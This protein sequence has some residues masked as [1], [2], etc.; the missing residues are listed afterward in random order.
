MRRGNAGVR[1]KGNDVS[2]LSMGWALGREDKQRD[3][4][5]E[6]RRRSEIDRG[7]PEGLGLD[8]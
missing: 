1:R 5:K 3:Q 2:S 6:K 4:V 7:I 8:R